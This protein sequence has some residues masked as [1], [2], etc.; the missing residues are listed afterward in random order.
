MLTFSLLQGV[1]TR[2]EFFGKPE[3][4]GERL[5]KIS[6]FDILSTSHTLVWLPTLKLRTVRRDIGSMTVVSRGWS[7][8]R[9]Y[10]K[11][12]TL[13]TAK[14]SSQPSSSQGYHQV[15][16]IYRMKEIIQRLQLGYVALQKE[17][18]V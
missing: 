11:V 10:C 4:L 6:D 17:K 9:S 7:T 3:V 13:D 8:C 1:V 5:L 16:L 15:I 2:K 14:E 18:Y 12:T